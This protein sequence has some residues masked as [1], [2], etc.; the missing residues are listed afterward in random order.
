[1]AGLAVALPRLLF[2]LSAVFSSALFSPVSFVP[3]VNL[4]LPSLQRLCGGAGGGGVWLGWWSVAVEAGDSSGFLFPS[5]EALLLLLVSFV[6]SV[7]VV[8]PSLQQ[9]HGGADG[10]EWLG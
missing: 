5:A 9:L 1:M 3:S 7:K 10:R 2:L 8:L 6:P 4:V